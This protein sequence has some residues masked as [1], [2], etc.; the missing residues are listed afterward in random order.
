MDMDILAI[1][2]KYDL[3]LRREMAGWI[4]MQD[5]SHRTEQDWT[6]SKRFCG[7]TPEEAIN[8]FLNHINK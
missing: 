1:M 4:V 7:N 6:S 2:E 5:N 8:E 3:T